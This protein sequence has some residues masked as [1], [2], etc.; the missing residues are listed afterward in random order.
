MLKY[1]NFGKQSLKEISEILVG[2]NLFLGMDVEGILGDQ[3]PEEKTET[4]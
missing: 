4:A 1:R 2:M 3:E